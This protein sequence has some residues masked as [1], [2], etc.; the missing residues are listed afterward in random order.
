MIHAPSATATGTRFAASRSIVGGASGREHRD[1]PEQLE[2]ADVDDRVGVDGPERPPRDRD[3]DRQ[4]QPD[5]DQGEVRPEQG[6]D[7]RHRDRPDRDH[8]HVRALERPE[9]ARR[10]PRP[11]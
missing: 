3:H 10:V 6:D 9:H 8:A 4:P 5:D 2:L 11:A 7:E 1:R